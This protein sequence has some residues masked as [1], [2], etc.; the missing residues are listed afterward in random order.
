MPS[1]ALTRI[2]KGNIKPKKSKSTKETKKTKLDKDDYNSESEIVDKHKIEESLSAEKLNEHVVNN[3]DIQDVNK[4]RQTAEFLVM[5]PALM[6]F[7][8][9]DIRDGYNNKLKQVPGDPEKEREMFELANEG[10]NSNS[11]MVKVKKKDSKKIKTEKF[12]KESDDDFNLKKIGLAQVF[13]L[14]DND[15]GSESS[16]TNVLER[17]N[18]IEVKK[19]VGNFE[20][21]N[22]YKTQ[23]REITEEPNSIL[24]DKEDHGEN[25]EPIEGEAGNII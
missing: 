22:M 12:F 9:L 15:I 4:S 10:N 16:R 25:E 19:K 17:I 23:K 2:K 20:I 21:S 14:N 6:S 7:N 11:E 3:Q 1:E 24:E 13:P 18:E 5:D 8:K